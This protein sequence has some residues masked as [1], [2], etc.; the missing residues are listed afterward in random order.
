MYKIQTNHLINNKGIQ[1][2]S[3][4]IKVAVI[5]S[6]FKCSYTGRPVIYSAKPKTQKDGIFKMDHMKHFT[7][8]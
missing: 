5:L 7:Y 1:N 8:W 3:P 4:I 2:C 6:K